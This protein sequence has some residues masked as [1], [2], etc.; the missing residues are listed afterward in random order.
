MSP[1]V[2]IQ[3]NPSSGAGPKR[4]LLI[5]LIDGLKQHNI[6][7]R[8]FRNRDRLKRRLENAEAREALVCIV[9]AGG[10]GT[11]ADV[12]NRHPG[13][14]MTVL[15]LG[16]ENLL[17]KYLG[18][19]K[20][21]SFVADIIAKGNVRKLDLAELNGRRFSLMTS[22]G[23]DADI[24]HKTDARRSGHISKLT[25]LMPILESL[26]DYKYPQ[27]SLYLDGS[28]D[29]VTA[30][31]VQIVNLPAYAL[32]M[33]FARSARGDDGLLDLR[34]FERGSRWNML[35]YISNIVMGG[36]HERLSDVSCLTAERIRVESEVPVPIQADGDP[37]G[38]T[39]AE[40]NVLPGAL[41]V[42]VP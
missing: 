13:V 29:P 10:D 40:I 14:R 37:A 21:G 11:V 7:T 4:D 35:R 15:P 30:K 3:R 26:K 9:A 42:I 5:Q 22:F 16:T 36:R 38:W 19:Q 39:P 34:L 24:V 18:I 12:I 31:T 27:L 32:G 41:E 6:R 33:P 28:E 23:I 8:L 1:W 2:A 17:S 25:Y 20:S